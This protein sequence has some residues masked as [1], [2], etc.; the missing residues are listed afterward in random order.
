MQFCIFSIS[1]RASFFFIEISPTTFTLNIKLDVK[2]FLYSKATDFG[3]TL[4]SNPFIT[5]KSSDK[6]IYS[7]LSLIETPFVVIDKSLFKSNTDVFMLS[8]L[9]IG[10]FAK[11]LSISF[12]KI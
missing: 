8:S 4:Y 1:I 10:L 3:A 6:T 11:T 5:S 12:G 2:I 9:Q 7:P